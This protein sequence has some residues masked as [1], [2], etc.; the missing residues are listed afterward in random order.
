MFRKMKLVCAV[1]VLLTGILG[2]L[3]M[4]GCASHAGTGALAGSGLGALTGQMIGKNTESTLIG[5]GIGAGVGYL[6]GRQSDKRKAVE[7]NV[8]A[9][10]APLGG[11]KWRV[12]SIKPAHKVPKFTSKV[13]EFKNDGHVVTTT[14]YPDKSRDVSTENY[15]VMGSTLIV[16]RKGYIINYQYRI[17]GNKMVARADTVTIQ[18]RRLR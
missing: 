9:T 2:M 10:Y 4:E 15:R 3:T 7:Q 8:R 11:T 1:L 13:V 17:N 5:A 18:L 14:T 12:I 16:N 6:I